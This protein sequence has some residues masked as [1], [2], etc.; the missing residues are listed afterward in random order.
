LRTSLTDGLTSLQSTRDMLSAL[1][2]NVA[3][4]DAVIASFSAR[5]GGVTESLNATLTSDFVRVRVAGTYDAYFLA[6]QVTDVQIDTGAG[7]DTVNSTLTGQ[8]R[9]ILSGGAGNDV[10]RSTGP[11]TFYGGSGN[12]QLHA[13]AA[14]VMFGDAGNDTLFGSTQS[15][16]MTGGGGKDLF[17]TSNNSTGVRDIIN[18]VLGGTRIGSPRLLSLQAPPDNNDLLSR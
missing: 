14:S 2:Q 16:T 10:V 15:D 7:S 8:R 9:L 12:D 11:T 18:G 1:G 13:G 3:R 17:V 4:L 6:S 5:I